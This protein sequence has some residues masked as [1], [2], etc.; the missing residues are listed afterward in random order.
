[1]WEPLVGWCYH[2]IPSCYLPTISCQCQS[3]PRRQPTRPVAWFGA[4]RLRHTWG[5]SGTFCNWGSENPAASHFSSS[6]IIPVFKGQTLLT[7][8]SKTSFTELWPICN[9]QGHFL[10]TRWF[11]LSIHRRSWRHGISLAA[12][13]QQ[14]C[15]CV[16]SELCIFEIVPHNQNVW[17]MGNMGKWWKM[18]R[19]KMSQAGTEAIHRAL[20]VHGKVT[21]GIK[22]EPKIVELS[23]VEGVC[24]TG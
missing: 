7:L 8:S 1:M 3:S 12:T 17:H 6:W 10:R 14:Q 21:P 5:R 18:N 11:C 4:V 19:A 9:C 24:R 20:V 23:T 13:T 22:G 2:V 15:G 16:L